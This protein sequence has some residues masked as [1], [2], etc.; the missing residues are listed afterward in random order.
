MVKF[1]EGCAV[2][3]RAFDVEYEK[4]GVI[5]GFLVHVGK[6]D[7]RIR[8]AENKEADKR[9]STALLVWLAK[10]AKEIADL[11]KQYGSKYEGRI[12]I[13]IFPLS[14]FASAVGHKFPYGDL[15]L[16]EFKA[17]VV[18]NGVKPMLGPNEIYFVVRDDLEIEYAKDTN[19]IEQIM[20]AL[21]VYSLLLLLCGMN[22]KKA[23]EVSRD[24]SFARIP[25]TPKIHTH[26]LAMALIG[27]KKTK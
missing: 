6:I 24:F 26:A 11:L 25:L 5:S 15:T 14:G 20:F 21:S 4:K 2:D 27:A 13:N 12:D 16:E 10:N 17:E 8:A 3:T 23:T 19:S 7:L 18:N 22:E 1:M 9:T